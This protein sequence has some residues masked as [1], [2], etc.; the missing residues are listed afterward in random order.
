MT[1]T[2][3]DNG[4]ILGED[5]KV[6]PLWAASDPLMR[7]YYDE[8]WGM[9]V[10]DEQGVYERIV[11]EGFQVGLSWATVLRKRENFREA[12]HNFE[13]D[14]VASFGEEKVEELLQNA[15]IIRQRAKINAA[16]NNARATQALREEGGLPQLVWSFKPEVTPRPLSMSEVAT[17]SEESK[18]LA[19][20]LKKKG[21]S[22]VGPTTMYALMEAIG[23][24]D[25]HVVGSHRRGTSGIWGE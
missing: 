2:S 13:V 25:N 19:K 15:G 7:Q 5:G 10:T 21:F 11:L 23:I 1:L 24:I 16:I 18:A 22:F 17:V 12:F 3:T 4:L 20:A 6:R 8:E 14:T 9:P